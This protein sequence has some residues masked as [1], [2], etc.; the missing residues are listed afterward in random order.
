MEGVDFF[1]LPPSPWILYGPEPYIGRPGGDYPMLLPE[2]SENSGDIAALRFAV[3]ARNAFDVMMRR[4]WN[5]TKHMPH[6]KH[7]GW[8]HV[9]DEWYDEFLDVGPWPDPFTALV[10]ADK[11]YRENMEKK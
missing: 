9:V 5:P 7:H 8:W 4:G 3:L 1:N 11:W 6:D 2:D 10:E